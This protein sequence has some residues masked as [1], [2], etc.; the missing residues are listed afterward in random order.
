MSPKLNRVLVVVMVLALVSLA[1][2]NVPQPTVVPGGK[3]ATPQEVIPSDTPI[4]PT[5]EPPVAT[6]APPPPPTPSLL[7]VTFEGLNFSFDPAIAS[8]AANSKLE[9]V[10]EG[11]GA[12]WEIQPETIQS[13]F[14]GYAHSG[15]FTDPVILVYPVQDFSKLSDTAA[16]EIDKLR[17]LLA[18]RPATAPADGMPFLPIWN[19]AQMMST[20]IDYLDFANG[21]GV[22]YLTQYG[23][24]AAPIN[25]TYLFYTFQGLTAD[26][27]YAVSAILPV[28]NPILPP[29]PSIIPGNDYEKF[30]NEFAT[31][32]ADIENKLAAQP[33]DSFQP[34]LGLLD[35]MIKTIKINK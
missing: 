7:S 10:G 4:P 9:P 22:R 25:N 12:P 28:A 26:G 33:D 32:L 34:H 8:S 1:C 27:K 16:Q 30:N 20:K 23:Q 11:Q 2:L 35:D 14:E 6:T 19:A 5:P 3:A 24:A 13:K 21:S 15:A 17:N 29:D 18:T 31:Y